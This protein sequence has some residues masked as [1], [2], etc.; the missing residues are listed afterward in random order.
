M[1]TSQQSIEY[2]MTLRHF[3]TDLESPKLKKNSCWTNLDPN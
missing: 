2:E 1:G 3:E